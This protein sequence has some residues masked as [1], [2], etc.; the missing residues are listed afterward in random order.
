[1]AG[2]PTVA[3]PVLPVIELTRAVAFYERLGFVVRSQYEGYAIVAFEGAELHLNEVPQLAGTESPAGAYLR[4][5]DADAVHARWTA[6]GAREVAPVADQPYGIREFA[7]E[8]L[9][10]N[11][12]RV[13]APVRG[14]PLDGWVPPDAP[15]DGVVS[16]AEVEDPSQVADLHD[17]GGPPGVDTSDADP[18]NVDGLALLQGTTPCPGCGFDPQETPSRALGAT[19]RDDV[20]AIGRLLEA[21]SDR[22]ARHKATPETWSAL[23]C[24]V[25]VRDVLRVFADRIVRTMAL[26]NPELGSWDHEAAMEEAMANEA[27]VGAV[28]DDLGRNAATLSEALRTV[29]DDDF[30]RPATRDGDPFTI[31]LL[32]RYALHEVVHHR[33]D[34][35]RALARAAAAPA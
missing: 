17:P 12:W 14:G 27:D 33:L 24:S 35:Q 30:E 10:G 25:H 28:V 34:V 23:E 13:G 19:A 9:D 8:D 20:H 15:V 1:M 21:A 32:A 31:D 29:G 22:D 5:A 26:T 18:A 11:L 7:T 4:V 6:L 3:V 16:L 2:E